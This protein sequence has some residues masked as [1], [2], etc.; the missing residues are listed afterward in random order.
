MKNF[1]NDLKTNNFKRVYLFYGEEDFLRFHYEKQ[2]IKKIA[3]DAE[4]MDVNVYDGKAYNLE[5][6]IK[7]CESPPFMA[8]KRLAVFK[9]TGLFAPGAK[10]EADKCEKY[11]AQYM[12]LTG[13]FFCVVIFSES[14]IDK[15][16]KLYK[17]MDKY[18]GTAEFKTPPEKELISWVSDMFIKNNRKITPPAATTLVR[19]VRDMN[20]LVMEADKLIA[21]ISA[22]QTAEE[23]DVEL[24]CAKNLEFKIFDLISAIG[25][26]NRALAINLYRGLVEAKESPI[27]V[28]SLMARQFGVITQTAELNAQRKSAAEIAGA[29]GVRPFVVYEALKQQKLFARENLSK[30]YAECLETDFNIKTGRITGETGV[31]LLVIKYSA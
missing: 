4:L 26:K 28:L 27:G 9:D 30:A 1:K 12:S 7:N 3:G 10:E 11:L 31:E 5:T 23:E 19:R 22:G 2:A 21:Y 13:D 16:G 20:A 24:I 18:G 14:K 25:G 6:L 17:L 29:L 8:D 15:R